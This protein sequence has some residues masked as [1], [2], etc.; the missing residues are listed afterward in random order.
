MR[1]KEYWILAVVA[2]GTF[3]VGRWTVN[4]TPIASKAQQIAKSDKVEPTDIALEKPD[5]KVNTRKLDERTEKWI[6][7]IKK[8]ASQDAV[9]KADKV[10]FINVRLEELKELFGQPSQLTGL[11]KQEAFKKYKG[12][13][14][15]WTGVLTSAAAYSSN[16]IYAKF[17]HVLEP[18]GG[19]KTYRYPGITH[20]EVSVQFPALQKHKLLKAQKGCRITYQ[21]Q[22]ND[23]SGVYSG[24]VKL[25]NGRLVSIER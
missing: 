9:E 2:V 7:M 6:S 18:I 24:S 15:Q 10:E 12:K 21:G 14:V 25:R 8:K 22:L 3:V 20:F 11:Q 4:T 1:A 17:K 5:S 23:Y 16:E 19:K 13:W